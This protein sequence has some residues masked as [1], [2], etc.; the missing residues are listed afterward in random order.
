MIRKQ[1]AEPCILSCMEHIVRCGI[2]RSEIPILQIKWFYDLTR[3]Q[4]ILLTYFVSKSDADKIYLSD[5]A[6]AMGISYIRLLSFMP[7]I[8]M[9][10][11][12]RYIVPVF[13]DKPC[14]KMDRNAMSAIVDNCRYS[15]SVR[16]EYK[17][18]TDFLYAAS[19]VID[20][21]DDGLL[22]G[23]DFEYYL[24]EIISFS[25][26]LSI[27]DYASQN[28]LYMGDWTILIYLSVQLYLGRERN[29]DFDEMLQVFDQKLAN[30]CRTR[31]FDKKNNI[32]RKNNLVEECFSGGEGNER[33]RYLSLTK[34]AREILLPDLDLKYL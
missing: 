31:Y 13:D 23:R 22:F 12:K 7:E 11:R 1:L 30:K 27:I 2:I 21:L 18:T 24:Y 10:E 34:N 4:T 14:Y 26:S 8:E 6:E 3:V 15:D 9:L 20:R 17:S 5:I 19:A 16:N 32:L 28:E 25:G 33:R 29:V